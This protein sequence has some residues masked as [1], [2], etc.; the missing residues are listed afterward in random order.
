MLEESRRYLK[1]MREF[2]L[3]QTNAYLIQF[4][5]GSD[6]LGGQKSLHQL[7]GFKTIQKF[8]SR[9]TSAERLLAEQY[10]RLWLSNARQMISQGNMSTNFYNQKLVSRRFTVWRLAVQKPNR[11]TMSDAVII[12]VHR[13]L[14]QCL[15]AWLMT[16]RLEKCTHISENRM[17]LMKEK[18]GR[19]IQWTTESSPLP[20]P[21]SVSTLPSALNLNPCCVDS[22]DD[23]QEEG[24]GG[25]MAY[26][27]KGTF[28]LHSLVNKTQANDQAREQSKAANKGRRLGNRSV[29][30]LGQDGGERASVDSEQSKLRPRTCQSKAGA[31]S[32]LKRSS[33][34]ALKLQEMQDKRIRHLQESNERRK[35][36]RLAKL[37]RLREETDRAQKVIEE[38]N[39]RRAQEVKERRLRKA[40]RQKRLEALMAKERVNAAKADNFR[41]YLCLKYHGFFPWMRYLQ[42]FHDDV[43]RACQSNQLRLQRAPFQAWLKSAQWT[44]T[45][46]HAI[47]NASYF[48]MLSRKVFSNLTQAVK[49]RQ[50]SMQNASNFYDQSVLKKYTQNWI[51]HYKRVEEA[52]LAKSEMAANYFVRTIQHK[53]FERMVQTPCCIPFAPSVKEENNA[54]GDDDDLCV[55]YKS[56]LGMIL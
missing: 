47:A 43:L 37:A 22:D 14:R 52:N 28:C 42:Q 26:R 30:S 7:V 16:T 38:E 41:R 35:Q 40:E 46:K 51:V 50:F 8:Q 18:I 17:H 5:G 36:V 9:W 12:N 45:R 23:K 11:P 25:P 13:M 29:Q 10:F 32:S 31:T 44:S 34:V 54:N 49:V 20:Q 48:R 4:Q 39:R 53:C 1:S 27:N 21:E 3:R 6:A 56:P 55:C 15:I 19:F 24:T 33:E 2:L